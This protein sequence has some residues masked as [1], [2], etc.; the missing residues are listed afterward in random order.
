MIDIFY[1]ICGKKANVAGDMPRHFDG[2][3]GNSF[4]VGMW[5]IQSYSGIFPL[6][7]LPVR[8]EKRKKFTWWGKTRTIKKVIHS[9][10]LRS[11][12]KFRHFFIKKILRTI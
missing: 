4:P 6:S 2:G 3:K 10:E 11:F 9:S 1:H 8:M 5:K 12:Q 7:F